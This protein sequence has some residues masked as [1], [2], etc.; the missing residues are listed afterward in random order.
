MTSMSGGRWLLSGLNRL[1]SNMLEVARS[2]PSRGRGVALVQ[3]DIEVV[4]GCCVE[5]G[6]GCVMQRYLNAWENGLC[7]W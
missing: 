5:V 2:F 3:D 6:D 7:S 1:V 4:N